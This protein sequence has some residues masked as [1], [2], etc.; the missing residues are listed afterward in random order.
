M[1][2]NGLE[3]MIWRRKIDTHLMPQREGTSDYSIG[4]IGEA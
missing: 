4:Y 2:K 1:T 3:N